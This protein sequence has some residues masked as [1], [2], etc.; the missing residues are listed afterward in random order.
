MLATAFTF[1]FLLTTSETQ[2]TFEIVTK[3]PSYI[4]CLKSATDNAVAAATALPL[5]NTV[6]TG[7][8]IS[9]SLLYSDILPSIRME[10]PTTTVGAAF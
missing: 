2:V 9:V 3:T 10:S 7:F 5:F 1:Q 6:I 4:S 8:V